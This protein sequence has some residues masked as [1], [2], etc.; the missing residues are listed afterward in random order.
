MYVK[1]SI[2]NDLASNAIQKK[3]RSV[4]APHNH[5]PFHG[6]DQ[7]IPAGMFSNPEI[8]NNAIHAVNTNGPVNAGR[9]HI[10]KNLCN[11]GI[12]N[13]EQATVIKTAIRKDCTVKGKKAVRA[14]ITKT[15]LNP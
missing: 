3:W 4:Q 5:L 8:P 10:P 12:T 6:L 7:P 15:W 11:A 14:I 2:E 13:R 1:V 9:P